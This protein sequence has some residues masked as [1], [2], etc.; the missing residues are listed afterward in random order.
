MQ[1]IKIKK[2]AVACP[3]EHD[4][5]FP[6]DYFPGGV[7]LRLKS[8]SKMLKSN[9]FRWGGG[10]AYWES[11]PPYLNNGRG[12]TVVRWFVILV[13]KIVLGLDMYMRAVTEL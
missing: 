2:C 8:T 12:N 4:P 11:P 5:L 7:Q 6:L 9:N 3:N 10:R 1:N 13:G